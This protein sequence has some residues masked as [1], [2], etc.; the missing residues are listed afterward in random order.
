MALRTIMIFP[1]F[2]DMTTIAQIRSQYDP[3]SHLVRPH[4]TLA[5]HEQLNK[6][7]EETKNIKE[8]WETQIHKVSVE[9][10]GAHDESIIIIEKY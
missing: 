8:V 2:E 10:I 4:I 9:M 6:A 3:L 1:E 5:T 7:Y